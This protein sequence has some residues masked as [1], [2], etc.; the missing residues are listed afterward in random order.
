MEI[1]A[2]NIDMVLSEIALGLFCLDTL[3]PT[4]HISYANIFL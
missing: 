2:E 4:V 1:T 3:S